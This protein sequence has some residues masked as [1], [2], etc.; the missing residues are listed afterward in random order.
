MQRTIVGGW[1][2]ALRTGSKLGATAQALML[3][4]VHCVTKVPA[5]HVAQVVHYADGHE[6]A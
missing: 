6:E 4:R 5:A 2:W 3:N 1:R